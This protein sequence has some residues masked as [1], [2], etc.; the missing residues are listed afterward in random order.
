MNQRRCDEF[1]RQTGVL[2]SRALEDS[3]GN[4]VECRFGVFW[5]GCG[6]LVVLRPL[7]CAYESTPDATRTKEALEDLGRLLCLA[8]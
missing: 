8:R 4:G 1:R 3:F 5:V 7:A 6:M 2:T